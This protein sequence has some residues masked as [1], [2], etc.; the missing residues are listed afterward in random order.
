MM[1]D[2]IAVGVMVR[3]RVAAPGVADDTAAAAAAAT[4]TAAAATFAIS[5][6]ASRVRLIRIVS[7]LSAIA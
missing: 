3:F 5:F 4:A 1:D 2:G 7:R 6:A